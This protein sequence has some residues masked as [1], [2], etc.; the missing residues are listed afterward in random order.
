MHQINVLMLGL[1]RGGR[2]L[3]TLKLALAVV[4]ALSLPM[5]LITQFTCCED[6]PTEA[7][8][9]PECF[10]ERSALS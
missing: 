3:I 4:E 8:A 6:T 2:L 5:A 1:A 10:E 7:G 9:E